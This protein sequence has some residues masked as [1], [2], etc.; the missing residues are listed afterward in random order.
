MTQAQK[1][2]RHLDDYGS[3]TPMEAYQEY[4]IMRLGARVWDLRAKGH[5]IATTLEYGVNRYGEPTR[6]ARYS[7]V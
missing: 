5:E 4:G 1:S 6:W 3:I 2:L 7:K